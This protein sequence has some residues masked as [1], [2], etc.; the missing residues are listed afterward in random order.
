MNLS[1]TSENFEI[2]RLSM[3]QT[4]LAEKEL[5]KDT[6][7]NGS[8]EEKLKPNAR[9]DLR[10]IIFILVLYVLQSVPFGLLTSIPLIL[11]SRKSSYSDQGLISIAFWPH[12][13]KILWAPLLDSFYS[14]RLGR[15]KTWI[16]FFE[17]LM[18]VVSLSSA[19]YLNKVLDVESSKTRS[20]SSPLLLN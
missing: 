15:R 20:G 4:E 11:Q 16:V 14:E 18:G 9:K 7:T 12:A 5:E 19:A 2:A 13:L 3:I 8:N 17:I 1:I 6:K 10:N